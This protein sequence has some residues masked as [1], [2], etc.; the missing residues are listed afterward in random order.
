MLE[1]FLFQGKEDTGAG[2]RLWEILSKWY[3]QDFW[4]HLYHIFLPAKDNQAS[5]MLVF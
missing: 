2:Q 4:L 1:K 3:L 5:F